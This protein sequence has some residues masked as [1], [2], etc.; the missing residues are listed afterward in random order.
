M[1]NNYND[2]IMLRYIMYNTYMCN[3]MYI[4]YI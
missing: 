2:Y 4:N 1:Y 3:I